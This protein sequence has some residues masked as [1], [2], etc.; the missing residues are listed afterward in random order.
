ML[1][2]QPKSFLRRVLKGFLRAQLLHRATPLAARFLLGPFLRSAC[3]LDGADDA[4]G[5]VLWDQAMNSG[6]ALAGVSLSRD[7]GFRMFRHS[8]D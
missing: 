5:L 4:H 2:K 6:D 3:F 7:C 1:H 8:R